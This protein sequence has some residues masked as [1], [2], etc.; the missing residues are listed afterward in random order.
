MQIQNQLLAHMKAAHAQ[1]QHERH[2]YE[3]VPRHCENVKISAEIIEVALIEVA[4]KE[5]GLIEVALIEV[6]L[7]EV[8]PTQRA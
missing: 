6:A 5:V 4:L 7:M 8:T 3:N 1:P 2:H